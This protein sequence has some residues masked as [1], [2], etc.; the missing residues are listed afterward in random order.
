[1]PK[2]KPHQ[3]VDIATLVAAIGCVAIAAFSGNIFALG[4]WV[5][6]SLLT[7]GNIVSGRKV[8]RGE[9]DA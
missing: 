4:G 7:V 2:Q 9:E 3:A 8:Q 5:V 1:M 6:V